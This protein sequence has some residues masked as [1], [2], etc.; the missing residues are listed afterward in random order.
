MKHFLSA[1]LCAVFLL[2]FLLLPAQ[3]AGDATTVHAVAV[4]LGVLPDGQSD[5]S[6]P[7]TRG[8]FSKMLVTASTL[9]GTVSPAGNASPY[10]DVPYTHPYASYIKTAVQKGWLSGYL[11]GAFRPDKTVTF[12]S[13]VIP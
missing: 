10:K 12:I 6:R 5:P 2:S 9:K 13:C 7:V 8:E 11:D 3:A 4:E 1:A